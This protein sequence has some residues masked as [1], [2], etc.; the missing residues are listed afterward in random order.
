MD[1]EHHGLRHRRAV[2]FLHDA[3]P[4]PAGG[5]EFGDLGEKV[6]AG[7]ED[8]AD[9][10]GEIIDFL[11]R[12]DSSVDVGHGIGKRE[13]DFLDWGSAG[14]TDMIGAD[15]DGIPLGDV[16][17]AVR[18]GI[19][20]EAHGRARRED[21]CAAGDVLLQDIVLDGAAQH[22]GPDSLF[23]RHGH[24]HGEQYGCRTVDGHG[25][26]NL[27]QGDAFEESFHIGQGVNGDTDLADFPV[28]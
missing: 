27:V 19:R 13:G 25:G 15:T 10:G 9:A 14:F 2:P 26:G 23:F 17:G 18:E 12:L 3:G 5:A 6:E 7:R 11:T 1:A 21:V 20:N 24:V 22:F 16:P 8:P 28:G 4:Q